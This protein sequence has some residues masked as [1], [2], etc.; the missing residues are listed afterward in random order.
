M[1]DN[2]SKLPDLQEV[3]GMAG[4]FFSDLKHS[5][6]EI[7]QDYKEKRKVSSSSEPQEASKTE[8]SVQPEPASKPKAAPA[9]KKP[10][11]TVRKKTEKTL[12]KD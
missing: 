10:K 6:C 9:Q 5:V 7:I 4:K 12:K 11:A 2:K 8:T 1:A 3:A